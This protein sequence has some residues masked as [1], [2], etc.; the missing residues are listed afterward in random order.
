MQNQQEVEEYIGTEDCPY[1]VINR[2]EGIMYSRVPS[3][4]GKQLFFLSQSVQ[5]ALL[6]NPCNEI[7]DGIFPTKSIFEPSYNKKIWW[8]ALDKCSFERWEFR[9][10]GGATMEPI[11]E[12]NQVRHG[13]DKTE[14]DWLWREWILN[15]LIFEIKNKEF[16]RIFLVVIQISQHKRGSRDDFKV[17]ACVEE[18]QKQALLEYTKDAVTYKKKFNLNKQLSDPNRISTNT[19]FGN[20]HPLI[21]TE[22]WDQLLLTT[23]IKTRLMDDFKSFTD[24]ADWFARNDI[25]WS[26]GYLIVGPSGSGKKTLLRAMAKCEAYSK[27]AFLPGENEL[28]LTN[29]VLGMDDDFDHPSLHLIPSIDLI[30]TSEAYQNEC[31]YFTNSVCKCKAY[32]GL[33][34]AATTESLSDIDPLLLK[35]GWPFNQI[36]YVDLPD[37]SIRTQKLLDLFS[38][39]DVCSVQEFVLLYLVERT[40]GFTFGQLQEVMIQ[41]KWMAQERHSSLIEECDLIQAVENIAESDQTR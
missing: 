32:N 18:D 15:D 11:V 3:T 7:M 22:T 13:Y 24:N 20:D 33:V 26:R 21:N 35:E 8:E 1:T 14:P 27:T 28:D 4:R 38:D 19:L 6:I 17:F 37:P 2:L 40:D 41:A 16:G 10:V 23:E 34:I 30:Y 9:L 39:D 25:P 29:I 31:E 12:G 36:I 5:R